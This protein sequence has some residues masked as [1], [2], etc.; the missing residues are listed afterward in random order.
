M[1]SQI[2]S[3]SESR[4]NSAGKPGA[5]GCVACMHEEAITKALGCFPE[6]HAE[7]Q[8]PWECPLWVCVFLSDFVCMCVYCEC[9]CVCGDVRVFMQHPLKDFS[10]A[11]DSAP[12]H[13]HLC[14]LPR[15]LL[16]QYPSLPSEG[17]QNG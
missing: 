12:P 13:N 4:A 11:L 6:V 5:P 15:L 10:P 16:K 17:K 8:L 7:F 1:N 9:V 2:I 14:G 3:S